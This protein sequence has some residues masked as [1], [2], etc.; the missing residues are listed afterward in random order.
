MYNLTSVPDDLMTR[1]FCNYI[2]GAVEAC[3]DRLIGVCNTEEEV[4]V[5][6]ERRLMYLH[7]S[8]EMWDTEKC[9]PVK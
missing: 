8:V 9:Q 4:T 6:K 1:E 5:L 3:S 7:K 2:A